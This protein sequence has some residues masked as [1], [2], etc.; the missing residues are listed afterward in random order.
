[1]EF[2]N[3]NRLPGIYFWREFAEIGGL[4]SYGTSNLAI[5][6]PSQYEL[7]FNLKTAKAIGLAIPPTL[8]LRADEVIQ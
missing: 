4:A 2:A 1:M 7:I 6:L 5:E 8:L 3:R